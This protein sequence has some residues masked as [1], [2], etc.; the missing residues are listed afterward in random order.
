M[1]G[2]RVSR[3]RSRDGVAVSVCS[4]SNSGDRSRSAARVGSELSV[5]AYVLLWRE[6]ESEG[7]RKRESEKERKREDFTHAHGVRCTYCAHCALRT[8][9]HVFSLSLFL[10]R[11]LCPSFDRLYSLVYTCT[12]RAHHARM[13]VQVGTSYIVCCVDG[14]SSDEG[15]LC[16]TYT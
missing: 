9:T 6:S 14:P 8:H 5:R 10:I 1:V 12:S 2:D 11:S 13:C 16:I 3:I 15:G 4:P 7:E